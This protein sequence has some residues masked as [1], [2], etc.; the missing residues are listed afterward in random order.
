MCAWFPV[1]DLLH[2]VVLTQ[3]YNVYLDRTS[4][5][6]S[7][8]PLSET[9]LQIVVDDFVISLLILAFTKDVGVRS[10]QDELLGCVSLRGRWQVQSSR[11]GQLSFRTY[12]SSMDSEMGR[13]FMQ[14]TKATAASRPLC[15]TCM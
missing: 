6:A 11:Q 14:W 5:E 15:K 8:V 3:R 2:S 10:V 13:N 9:S 4:T 1:E 7:D 12:W